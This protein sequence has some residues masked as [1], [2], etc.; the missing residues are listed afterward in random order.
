MA[1]L[2]LPKECLESTQVY[3]GL[4]VTREGVEVSDA[5]AAA[6]KERWPELI[7]ETPSVP[8]RKA[9]DKEGDQ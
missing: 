1:L 6:A 2:K 9:R 3:D 4:E 8:G 7:V 5:V